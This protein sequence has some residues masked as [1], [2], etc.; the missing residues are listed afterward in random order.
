MLTIN[1]PDTEVP[2]ISRHPV[3]NIFGTVQLNIFIRCRSIIRIVNKISIN[4]CAVSDQHIP[5]IVYSVFHLVRVQLTLCTAKE[6]TVQVGSECRETKLPSWQQRMYKKRKRN[7]LLLLF[8]MCNKARKCDSEQCVVRRA[9]VCKK[10]NCIRIRPAIQFID[11][12]HEFVYLIVYPTRFS[13]NT[14][15]QVSLLKHY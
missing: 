5:N 14:S 7:G 11:I 13:F 9:I 12:I 8:R 15:G 6:Q 2:C 10:E 4:I 3:Y 1:A